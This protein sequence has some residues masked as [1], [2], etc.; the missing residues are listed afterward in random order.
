MTDNAVLAAARYF[1]AVWADLGPNL[2]DDYDCHLTCTEADAL[3]GLFQA[4]GMDDAADSL[5]AAHAAHD[6]EG[7]AHYRGG[8]D[9]GPCGGTG[10]PTVAQNCIYCGGSGRVEPAGL[11]AS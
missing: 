7:D 4:C 5:L 10:G 2:P 6:D 9:C 11:T 8:E 1:A 3:A